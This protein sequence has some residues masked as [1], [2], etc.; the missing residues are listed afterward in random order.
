LDL[1][2]QRHLTSDPLIREA[3][4]ELPVPHHVLL[5]ALRGRLPLDP[6]RRHGR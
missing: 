1:E 3:I 6:P 4:D 5:A 2:R